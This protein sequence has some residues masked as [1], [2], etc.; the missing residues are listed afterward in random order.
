MTEP[1]YV[2]LARATLAD[3]DFVAK[4]ENADDLARIVLQLHA[5]D[6]DLTKACEELHEQNAKLRA[7]LRRTLEG[8]CKCVSPC[9]RCLGLRKLAE[10]P[11]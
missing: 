1:E 2:R 9:E 3:S 6:L 5:C 4:S 11:L 8:P 7:G 10:E